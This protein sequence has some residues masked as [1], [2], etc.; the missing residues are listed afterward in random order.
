MFRRPC[1]V[2]LAANYYLL[3]ECHQLP[4]VCNLDFTGGEGKGGEDKE[5]LADYEIAQV[6]V[7][8]RHG[9]RTNYHH[10]PNVTNPHI[11]SCEL[12]GAELEASLDW[13]HFLEAADADSKLP[14]ATQPSWFLET[15]P[16]GKSCK[17]SVCE[18][19]VC[20]GGGIL[21]PAG[22]RQL[23]D[24]GSSLQKAYGPFLVSLLPEDVYVRSIRLPRVVL[25]AASFLKGVIGKKTQHV[26][27]RKF[28]IHI[29][30]N[31][32]E[33]TMQGLPCPQAD[34]MNAWQEDA[35]YFPTEQVAELGRLFNV[36]DFSPHCRTVDPNI[37][38]VA[39]TALCDGGELPCGPGGCIS[40]E[41]QA[42]LEKSYN[43]KWSEQ[44]SG[45]VGG[46]KAS[47]LK[48]YPLLK[49]VVDHM[50][51]EPSSR[52]KLA[53]YAGRD[54]VIGPLAAALGIFDG[55]W[56]PFSAHIVFELW[57]P[58]ES[59]AGSAM[60]R[61]LYDGNDVTSLVAGCGGAA[62]CSVESLSLTLQGFLSPSATHEAACILT[63]NHAEV[64]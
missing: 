28:K 15:G 6:Q 11:F 22:V 21:L 55:R 33:E 42:R 49:E 14:L 44:N 48:M 53:V 54:F 5:F 47:Q 25:S 59:V 10:V 64:V 1:Q 38:D 18:E 20:T 36:S 50:S 7:L 51:A 4:A 41:L 43:S 46:Q 9:A 63:T 17:E 26:P 52:P 61:V 31:E 2:Y 40:N 39:F 23:L 19:G 24:L 13:P 35:I 58:K 60:F 29:H 8:M 57:K 32:S 16:D 37:A 12:Q 34:K 56:P 30:S 3:S 62:L 27:S 45:N